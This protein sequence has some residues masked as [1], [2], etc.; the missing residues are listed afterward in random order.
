MTT[1]NIYVLRL[2]SG[3][4]YVGKS[5]NIMDRY[6][7]H[8]NQ[9]GSAWTKKYRP[10][11]IEKTF[12]N[13]SSFDE[14]KITKEYMSIHGIE[15]VR[16]GCYVEIELSDFHKDALKM[17][18]WGAK[19]LCTQCGRNG[20]WVKDCHAKIDV[21]GN[22]INYE[23]ET[24]A[25]HCEYCERTFTTSFGCSVHEKSCKEKSKGRIKKQETNNNSK[26]SSTCYRC[27]N[28]GHYSTQCY[29]T[30]D[31]HGDYLDNR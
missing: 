10:I 20:H 31:I 28:N 30:R 17:E 22:K 15:N 29:A 14:D 2:E 7:Q 12:E 18:I 8:L 16:G 27:G 21:L 24:Y 1:T 25:W 11:S 26:K 3:R 19:D 9:R 13:V 4:Y 5:D 6:K 23:E